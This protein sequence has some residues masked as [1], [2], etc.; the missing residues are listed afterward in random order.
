MKDHSQHVAPD[1]RGGWS[2]RRR[3]AERA[4]KVFD[5]Q[6]DAVAYAK[7]I[8]KRQGSNLYIHGKDGRIRSSDSYGSDP[9]PPKQKR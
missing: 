5:T 8:A 4:S 6:G 7:D 1:Q 2:V 3:G 9:L